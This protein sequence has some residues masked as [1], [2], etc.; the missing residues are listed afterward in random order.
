M[1]LEKHGKARLESVW[2]L[3]LRAEESEND[4]RPV[5]RR[6]REAWEDNDNANEGL[7]GRRANLEARVSIAIQCAI[8]KTREWPY[9][10]DFH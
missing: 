10:L 8:K 4:L 2:G 6:A 9:C 7:T 3:L 1:K 5:L